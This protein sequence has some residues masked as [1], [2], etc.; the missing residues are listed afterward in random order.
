MNN[1]ANTPVYTREQQDS[2]DIDFGEILR[3]LL[4]ARWLILA[5]AA[6]VFII[7]A[8]YA[9][10]SPPI[11][12]V[13]TMVQVE[14]SQNS[15]SN[16]LGE[17]AA[18]FNVQSPASA[19]IEI[20]RSR[21]VVGEAADDLQLY[22]S[23]SPKYLPLIGS[24]L[25]QRA[26]ELS[27]PG[28]FGFGGYVWGTESIRMGQLEV[29]SALEGK[30]LTLRATATGYELLTPE[31]QK[32]TEGKVGQR[33]GFKVGDETGRI[34]VNSLDAKPGA[35]FTV[36]RR[37]RLNMIRGLQAGL[38][39]TEKGRQSGVLA[40]TLQGTNPA[41]IT[42]ILNA[43]GD[44]YVQQNT[45]RKSAE[46]EKSLAFLGEFLPQLKKQMDE[47]ESRYT[48]FR[49]EHGTFDL[50]T[51]GNLSLNT[52]VSLKSQLFALQQRRRELSALFA[53]AHPNVQVVD[54]QIEA[55][56][57]EIATLNDRIK[58]M[59]DLQRQLLN[60]Q[61]DAQVNGELY[62]SL[63]N[64]EQQLQLVK[65][66]RV[67]NVR[68]VDPAVQ[69]ERP[70]KPD[71]TLI[72][73]AAALL[74]LI[75]GSA[76]ALMRDKMRKGIQEPGV[77]ENRLGLDV[78]ATVPHSTRQTRLHQLAVGSAAGNHVLAETAPQD[79]AIESLRN[80]RT[81]LQ[82]AML[83]ARNNIVLLTGPT[84]NIGKTFT[85]VNFAAL[86][87]AAEKRV[88]LL[89]AD[90]RRGYIHQYFGLERSNGFSE[91]ISGSLPLEQ[92]IHKNVL[93]NV[94]LITTG[95]LPPNPAELLMSPSVIDLLRRFSEEYDFVLLDSTPV[96]AVSD[97]LAL[98]SQAG[99]VF[100]LARAEISTLDELR[101][102][103]RRLN[104]AG[105]R[106]KGVIFNDLALTS[107]AGVK[108]GYNYNY[109]AKKP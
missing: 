41:R 62:V 22:V 66:G 99:T 20:V 32:L 49:D 36:T 75:L 77:I 95:V 85:I 46:A 94:D 100:L 70:I 79:P 27:N 7:G 93:P 81:T 21:L 82:F 23:S 12:Q 69:P 50:S 43:V 18:L 57:K 14:Q 13:D 4:D 1:S 83:N 67:G 59:P 17:A 34:L 64:S 103:T 38:E 3:T 92:G 42:R 35:E 101:E 89:D 44:A 54:Q 45:Q 10:L 28:L 102:A 11:Y 55:L 31:G 6:V 91:L 19:E 71:R 96:L 51:E 8:A 84:P 15:G 30:G 56:N 9:Y 105:T 97:T 108:Y 39:I 88:L 37:S 40:I 86:L 25:A 16:A 52:S 58:T 24:W 90:F 53:P 60:L 63:L 26:T 47:S 29:P 2:D 65:E 68:V 109:D 73:L 104:H 87:G 106:V 74:G 33:S 76:V 5:I 98:A 72:L 78:F 48:R 107:S 80:L 61:R